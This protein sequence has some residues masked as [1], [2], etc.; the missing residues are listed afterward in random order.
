MRVYLFFALF[1]LLFFALHYLFYSRVIK[2]LLVSQSVKHTLT[3]VLGINYIFTVLYVIGRY[4]N[5]IPNG[6]YYFFSLSIGMT[7]VLVLYMLI[8]EILNLFHKSL[9]N[10]DLSK[11]EF[12]KKSGDGAMLA[13]SSGYVGAAVYEGNKSPAINIVTLKHFDFTIVQISDLHIGGLIDK[14]FIDASVK[15]INALKPDIVCITGDIIDTALDQIED[16]VRV[17]DGIVSKH[18][19]YYVLGNHEY[20][21]DPLKIIDFLKTTNIKL[22]L[23][24]NVTIDALKLNEDAVRVLDG[25]VSKHG[26]YYVLGNHEYFHDPLKIIDFLKTTNIKLLLNENVTIDALKLNVVGVTDRMGYRMALLEPDIHKAFKGCNTAY[27]TILLAHQPRYIEELGNY[28]PDLVLSGHTHG[29]QIWPFEYL[30]RLQQP[31]VKGLHA[32]PYGGHIYVNSGIGFWGPPMR[33]GSHAEI[34]Y[35]V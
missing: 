1:L 8:H 24:E 4:T 28:R 27:K 30:V 2:K 31:Y 22:L 32:L 13:L 5:A 23:N 35:I 3:A 18:G 12:F 16:A 11:R 26:V 19:V 7:L 21:H 33:L 14:A 29:G 34:A 9:K 10:V 25:I 20:F 15:D 6:L 17:L